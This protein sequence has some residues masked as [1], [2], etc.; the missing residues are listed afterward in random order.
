M[1][2]AVG[3]LKL[4]VAVLLL[5]PA[6]FIWVVTANTPKDRAGVRSAIRVALA[7]NLATLCLSLSVWLVV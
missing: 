6:F 7:L 3:M 1:S 4:I 5:Y 2:G